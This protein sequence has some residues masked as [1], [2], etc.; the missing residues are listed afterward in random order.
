MV[1]AAA[2]L[3]L[4]GAGCRFA[5]RIPAVALGREPLRIQAAAATAPPKATP[6]ADATDSGP[7]GE[8]TPAPRHNTAPVLAAATSEESSEQPRYEIHARYPSLE[9]EGDPRVDAFNEAA[10]KFA[11]DEMRSFKENVYNIPNESP[12]NELGSFL[13]MDFTLTA[14]EQGLLSVLYKTSYYMAGAAHPGSYSFA[15]NYDLETG[16]VLELTDLFE[17]DAPYLDMLSS[18]CIKDLK[19]RGRLDWEEGALPNAENY[20]VW[21]ITP[22][23]LLITFDEYQVAPYAAGPQSVTVPYDL[24]RPLLRADSPLQ[25]VTGK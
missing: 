21:N 11:L 19:Q 16:Q 23:G 2:A 4:A 24:L 25:R 22:D 17:A 9:W 1:W 3:L 15:L 6:R 12:F 18:A 10:E 13:E 14:S 20:R 5:A 7:A 8:S